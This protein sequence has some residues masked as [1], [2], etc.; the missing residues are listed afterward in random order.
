MNT[1]KKDWKQDLGI[2]HILLVIKCLLIAPNA[3][4]A[5][6]EDAAKLLLEHYDEYSKRA[7]MI[8]EIHAK[9]KT[10]KCPLEPSSSSETFSG[11]PESPF[12]SVQP[13]NNNNPSLATARKQ[14]DSSADGPLPKK[15]AK[16]VVS[17]TKSANQTSTT[18]SKPATIR[19]HKKRALKRL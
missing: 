7:Q 8:T 11:D 9:P 3:E 1:L 16:N 10:N 19:D 4:S 17:S 12:L 2:K 15:M 6:N 18:S 14:S 13:N 5:L